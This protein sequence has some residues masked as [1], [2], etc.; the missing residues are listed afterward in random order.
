VSTDESMV[1]AAFRAGMSLDEIVLRSGC[2]EALVRTLVGE[3]GLAPRRRGRRWPYAAA[4]EAMI[5]AEYAAGS[6]MPSIVSRHGGNNRSIRQ[7]LERRGV[8]IR[9]AGRRR[10]RS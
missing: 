3:A 1:V 8:P 5:A 4:T 7:V 9:A 2:T 10:V 6:T